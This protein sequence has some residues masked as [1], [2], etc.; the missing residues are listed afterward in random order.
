MFNEI[1]KNCWYDYTRVS[2]KFQEDNSSLETQKRGFI[3]QRVPKKNIQFKVEFAADHFKRRLV[4]QRLID[5]ELKEN[6]LLLVTKIN[7]CSRNTL[8]FLKL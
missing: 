3:Q 5:Q 8:E 2:S 6:D 4:F 7:R 1:S